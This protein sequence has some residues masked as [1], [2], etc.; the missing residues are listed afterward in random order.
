[1]SSSS[2]SFEAKQQRRN[3]QLLMTATMMQPSS[4]SVS[5][6]STASPVIYEGGVDAPTEY[7]QGKAKANTWLEVARMGT[8]TGDSDHKN[9]ESG[10]SL[11]VMRYM[12][13]LGL[14]DNGTECENVQQ[15]CEVHRADYA[16]LLTAQAGSAEAEKAADA[17][18][19]ADTLDKDT[20]RTFTDHEW[21]N[22]PDTRALIRRVLRCYLRKQGSVY[23]QGMTDI[24]GI[25]LIA[26]R[27]DV[28]AHVGLL[29]VQDM[30]IRQHVLAET[31]MES[32]C[33]ALFCGVMEH[34][35]GY[36]TAGSVTDRTLPLSQQPLLCQRMYFLWHW[37]LAKVDPTLYAHLKRCGAVEQGQVFLVR[38]L[39]VLFSREFTMSQTLTVWDLV[40][41]S[42]FKLVEYVAV[43]MLA[44]LRSDLL[45]VDDE[46]DGEAAIMLLV[47]TF[48]PSSD[49][50]FA[51]IL[52]VA[53]QLYDD[54]YSLYAYSGKGRMQTMAVDEIG[55]DFASDP[56]EH[57]INKGRQML[58]SLAKSLF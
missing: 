22:L 36:Y 24:L 37:L 31:H 55:D 39:R 21:F 27:R 28:N 38:W 5:S 54:Y 8:I 47:H 50:R 2:S 11:A 9:N 30:Y 26:Y 53:K 34:M 19:D 57:S 35:A 12:M 6:S 45:E 33:Y 44:S 58:S 20:S 10:T 51:G 48:P 7:Q 17:A 1:M 15:A 16:A 32:D 4:S 42:R 18:I 23:Q 40:I 29:D 14:L 3:S 49:S 52:H 25:L 13:W 41:R 46:E 56:L 43:A